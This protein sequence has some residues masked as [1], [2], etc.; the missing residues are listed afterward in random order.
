MLVEIFEGIQ[1]PAP[2]ETISPSEFEDL[3]TDMTIQDLAARIVLC[4]K[5][6]LKTQRSILLPYYL[7]YALKRSVPIPYP[8]LS[9]AEEQTVS[10]IFP[11]KYK[12]ELTQRDRDSSQM[13]EDY[14]FDLIPCAVLETWNQCVALGM[15]K[16]FEIWTAE[17]L[18]KP[19]PVLIGR[20]VEH[21]FPYL[22]A[23]WG[24]ALRPWNELITGRKRTVGARQLLP[25]N[26]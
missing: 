26:F 15:F 22:L 7:A 23:R 17:R 19:D 16:N 1:K 8:F 12:K 24:E 3:E 21:P 6:G 10:R 11:T 4:A 13:L 20:R 2:L 18:K 5:V 14:H 25:N 9:P